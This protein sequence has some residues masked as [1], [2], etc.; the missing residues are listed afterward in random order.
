MKPPESAHHLGG[1]SYFREEPRT[2]LDS[3]RS[4]CDQKEIEREN[5]DLSACMCVFQLVRT[6]SCFLGGEGADRSGRHF[7]LLATCFTYL[8]ACF[9]ERDCSWRRMMGGEAGARVWYGRRGS[10]AP[11]GPNLTHPALTCAHKPLKSLSPRG[12]RRREPHLPEPTDGCPASAKCFAPG[13]WLERSPRR[14]PLL[15]SPR[16]CPPLPTPQPPRALAFPERSPGP[17]THPARPAGALGSDPNA[18]LGCFHEGPV[19]EALAGHFLCVKVALALPGMGVF[20][21]SLSRILA[22]VCLAS[23]K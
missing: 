23:H 15:R 17:R 5:I 9:S 13:G 16:R 4:F 21:L 19:P 22:R 8:K 6:H 1:V 10:A 20:S 14:C 7:A 11:A 18:S 3:Q 2:A 12:G